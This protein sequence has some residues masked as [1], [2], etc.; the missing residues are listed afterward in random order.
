MDSIPF[1]IPKSLATYVDQFNTDPQKAIEKLKIHIHRR[2]ND[3]VALFI[4]AWFYY[5]LDDQKQAIENA[6]KA[7]TYA[8][9]SPF[10]EYLHYFLIHPN[11]FRAW[12]PDNYYRDSN[13]KTSFDLNIDLL[14]DLESLIKR[15]TEAENKKIQINEE[16][17]IED[18]DLSLASQTIDDIASETLANIYEE[19]GKYKEA[20][21]I[22]KKLCRMMPKKRD[23]F[24]DEIAKLQKQID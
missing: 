8:P 13:S 9:G 5:N 14:Q 10:L 2:G 15:L 20:I 12:I 22:Y 21:N 4:L 16:Q 1:E 17:Q 19:Q 11:T 7:K 18:T 23:H 3:A 6:L 24:L